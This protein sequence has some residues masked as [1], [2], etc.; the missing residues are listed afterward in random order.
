MSQYVI[1]ILMCLA[2]CAT[3][4]D[5]MA[6]TT[7]NIDNW[8][9]SSDIEPAPQKTMP[10]DYHWANSLALSTAH[11]QGTFQLTPQPGYGDDLFLVIPPIWCHNK[12]ALNDILLT[13]T[14]VGSI[15]ADNI[16]R[17]PASTLAPSL[18]KLNSVTDVLEKNRDNISKALPGLAKYQLTQ[19][20]TVSSGYY[21][22]PYIPNLFTLQFFQWLFD[23]TWGFRAYGA[24]GSPPDTAGPRAP[25]PFPFNKDPGGSR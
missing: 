14:L 17:I 12:V 8:R 9:V 24:P 11:Y 2:A 5:A 25:F 20:E 16:I 1:T 3:R 7:I 10:L 22:N 13:K 4:L 21:Y 23:Y 15:Y 19:G 18:A 6:N